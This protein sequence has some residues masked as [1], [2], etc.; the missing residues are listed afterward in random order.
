MRIGFRPYAVQ[1]SPDPQAY[2]YRAVLRRTYFLG[3]VL[4]LELILR[5]GLVIRSRI[6]KE[7]YA[8]LGLQDDQEVSIQIKSYRI[9]SRQNELGSE[10]SPVYD[11]EPKAPELA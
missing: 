7:E 3:V 6:G 2:R 4:R 1:V 8:R 10:V 5:S 11:L 9:L